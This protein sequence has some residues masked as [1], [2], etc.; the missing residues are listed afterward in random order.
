MAQNRK[1]PAYQEYA[2]SM[3]ANRQFKCMSF[4][5]RG[6]LYTLRLECWENKEV[7]SKPDELSKYLGVSMNHIDSSLTGRVKHFFIENIDSF[8]C[9]ELDNYRQHLDEIKIKQSA[10]GRKGAEKTNG[11]V[12]P[13]KRRNNA[14]DTNKSPT[15]LSGNPQVSRQGSGES[16]VK[17]ST[18]KQS[19]EQSLES[20][21]TGEWINEYNEGEH[22]KYSHIRE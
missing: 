15:N 22:D 3:L 8:S 9:P 16:L 1:A 21:V 4:S 18:V 2:S 6:L 20:D 13:S 19:Q 10:G 12:N 11:K 14:G 17:L 5:E 7:P